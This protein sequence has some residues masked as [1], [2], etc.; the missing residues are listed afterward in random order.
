M[1]EP[2]PSLIGDNDRYSDIDRAAAQ[3]WNLTQQAI[4]DGEVDRISESAIVDLLTASVKLYAAKVAS[5]AMPFRPLHGAHDE[6]VTPTE[7]LTATIEIL[8]SLNLGPM[9]LGLWSHRK[10]RNYH[11]MENPSVPSRSE[12]HTTRQP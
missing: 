9:E 10:P 7:A 11:L 12:E 2:S 5:E 8:R 1:C 6:V 4:Q 3:I